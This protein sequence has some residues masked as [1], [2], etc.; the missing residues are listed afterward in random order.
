M[1]VI[2]FN[3][4]DE[5]LKWAKSRLGL[6][7]DVGFCRVLS[8]VDFND[9]FVL[10]VVLSNFVKGNIDMHVAAA[11]G[12]QW[13][14]PKAIIE[15]FNS[16]FHYAFTRHNADRV[17]GLVPADNLEARR[18][19]EHLGFKLEGLMRKALNGKDLCIYGFLREEFET[20]PWYRGAV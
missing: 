4:E 5:A 3:R 1:K 16:V 17:T 8:A 7:E 20:H 14:R 12:G 18:F 9:S 2:G 6:T 15:M 19:D 11:P 13:A 10:T